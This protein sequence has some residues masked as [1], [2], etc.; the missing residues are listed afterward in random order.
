MC[1][2]VCVCV[3]VC[4]C[5]CVSACLCVC[6]SVSVSLSLGLC[7]FVCLCVLCLCVRR[8]WFKSSLP[9]RVQISF[10]LKNAVHPAVMTKS[11]IA[12]IAF[13]LVANEACALLHT[14]SLANATKQPLTKF[15]LSC[16]YE[17][18]PTG[19]L[20]GD[21]GRS[22]RGLASST[23]SGRTCQKWTEIHPHAEA[24]CS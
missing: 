16:Y 12:V 17:S 4:L 5:I 2:C 1:V 7:V 3:C 24:D 19:E 14:R 21:K 23:V 13:A 9:K 8:L 20:G 18:N 15:E 6:V 10:C 22:Y 11:L